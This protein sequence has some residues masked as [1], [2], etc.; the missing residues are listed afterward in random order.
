M[1]LIKTDTEKT[2]MQKKHNDK[3]FWNK[4]DK[5]NFFFKQTTFSMCVQYNMFCWHS[6]SQTVE[7]TKQQSVARDQINWEIRVVPMSHSSS[8]TENRS[9]TTVYKMLKSVPPKLK[10]WLQDN[11]QEQ[12]PVVM[13]CEDM[14][15]YGS[16]EGGW[17]KSS[18]SMMSEQVK[19]PLTDCLPAQTVT[20]FIYKKTSLFK[21]HLPH[22]S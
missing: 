7:R 8:C 11:N 22:Q 1:L 20:E 5:T 10:T 6:D 14:V 16:P 17:S 3:M 4:T 18:D 15:L 12:T 19:M 2:E 9:L 21:E 13:C